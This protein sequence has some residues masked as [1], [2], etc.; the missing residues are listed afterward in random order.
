MI[1]IT[2]YVDYI[3]NVTLHTYTPSLQ[4]VQ[5]RPTAAHS[6]LIY[7]H[8]EVSSGSSEDEVVTYSGSVI[9]LWNPDRQSVATFVRGTVS[10]DETTDSLL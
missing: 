9:I 7:L 5:I 8:L 3:Y 6:M 2:Y 10:N 4:P 1:Q